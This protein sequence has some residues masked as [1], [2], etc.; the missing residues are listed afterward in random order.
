MTD[1]RFDLTLNP[2][3][4]IRLVELLR[5]YDEEEILDAASDGEAEFEPPVDLDDFE[6]GE[7]GTPRQ[8]PFEDEMNSLI[9]SL[10]IDSQ[11]D[12]LALVWVGRGDYDARDWSQARRQARE[13]P[14][15]HIASYL[16]ETPL[17]SDY[18]ND[19]LSDL[20]YPT[21]DL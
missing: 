19:A 7:A 9:G 11:R 6:E 3:V 1:R 18:I 4:A 16:R 5:E 17:A 13:T 10:D 8:D 15:L 12:L 20:G 21:A 14:D 2:D